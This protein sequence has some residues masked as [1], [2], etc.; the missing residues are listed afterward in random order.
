V[1]QDG[2]VWLGVV[3]RVR[4]VSRPLVEQQVSRC[5]PF[6]CQSSIATRSVHAYTFVRGLDF[7]RSTASESAERVI[8]PSCSVL[9]LSVFSSTVTASPIRGL[10]SARYFRN[11]TCNKCQLMFNF[12]FLLLLLLLT[13]RITQIL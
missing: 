7:V 2:C 5:M 11:A 1:K 10:H 3:V 8:S 6:L 4:Q 13:I 9:V 12:F